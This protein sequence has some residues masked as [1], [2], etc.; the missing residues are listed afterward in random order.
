MHTHARTHACAHTHAHTH[1]RTPTAGKIW[2]YI[3][4]GLKHLR[5]SQALNF[6]VAASERGISRDHAG[7]AHSP[8]AHAAFVPSWRGAILPVPTR[9]LGGE[10]GFPLASDWGP[11]RLEASCLPRSLRAPSSF[12]SGG[13]GGRASWPSPLAS[14]LPSLLFSFLAC[15]TCLRWKYSIRQNV[16]L[17]HQSDSLREHRDNLFHQ[18]SYDVALCHESLVNSVNV[19]KHPS[20]IAFARVFDILP[21]GFAIFIF[22]SGL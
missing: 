17:L 8:L 12:R 6:S 3:G 15:Q 1:M 18:I 21:R 2:Q 5:K 14:P 19:V 11:R 4:H 16:L 7:K 9:S 20:R 13:E 10:P 22:F